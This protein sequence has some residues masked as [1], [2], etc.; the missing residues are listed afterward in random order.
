[1]ES[2]RASTLALLHFLG[3]QPTGQVKISLVFVVGI[4]VK[5]ESVCFEASAN[6]AHCADTCAD[7]PIFEPMSK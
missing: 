1:M 4:V 7:W 3:H 2:P 5:R 6:R